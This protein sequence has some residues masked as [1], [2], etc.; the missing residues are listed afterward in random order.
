MQEANRTGGLIMI[1]HEDIFK[2]RNYFPEPKNSVSTS[3]TRYHVIGR[4]GKGW[5][6]VSTR[7]FKKRINRLETLTDQCETEYLGLIDILNY[8]PAGSRV[9]IKSDSQSMCRNFYQ[10]RVRDE[11]W[12]ANLRKQIRTLVRERKL[13]V[14]L[15][16]VYP[17]SH[18]AARLFGTPE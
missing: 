10:Q 2:T 7:P 3:K 11:R 9:V 18:F 15:K 5:A 4:A 12:T 13:E 8:V 6:W 1:K 14:D 16:Y 17:S